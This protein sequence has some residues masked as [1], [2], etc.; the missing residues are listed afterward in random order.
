MTKPSAGI[1]AHGVRKE[2]AGTLGW[3]MAQPQ[4]ERF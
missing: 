4:A 1:V 3:G 2:G